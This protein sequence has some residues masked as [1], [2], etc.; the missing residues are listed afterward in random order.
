[1]TRAADVAALVV[2]YF[3]ALD[4]KRALTGGEDTSTLADVTS[5]LERAE[6]AL[7][8]VVGAAPPADARANARVIAAFRDV[9]SQHQPAPGW[10]EQVW[11]GVHAQRASWW[12]RAWLRLTGGAS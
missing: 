8:E 7:R 2:E 11:T 6:V 12:R 4:A 3:W 5:A 9:G 10:Q 1:M